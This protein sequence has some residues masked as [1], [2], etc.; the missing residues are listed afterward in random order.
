LEIS[1]IRL[2]ADNEKADYKENVNELNKQIKS[3]VGQLSTF[4]NIDVDS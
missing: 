4:D 1:D 2:I 3:L